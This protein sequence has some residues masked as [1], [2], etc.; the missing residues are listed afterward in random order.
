MSNND[1][2]TLDAALATLDSNY[3]INLINN[4]Q[5]IGGL[6]PPIRLVDFPKPISDKDNPSAI[7]C[8]RYLRKGGG[9]VIVAPSG[10]GKSTFITAATSYWAAGRE[11]C[12]IKPARP[13]KIGVFQTEDDAD[14]MGEFRDD[15]ARLFVE[16]NFSQEENDRALSVMYEAIPIGKFVEHLKA[17][18]IARRYDLIVLNPL[19][20]F[21]DGDITKNVDLGAF[22]RHGIDPLLKNSKYGCGMVIIHHT[23]KLKTDNRGKTDFGTTDAYAGAGGAELTNWARGVLVLQEIGQ[24]TPREFFLI[25]AKRGTRL[26]WT[27][28]EGKPTT[29]RKLSHST[30]GIFWIDAGGVAA[31]N[32]TKTDANKKNEQS[33]ENGDEWSAICD[34]ALAVDKEAGDNLLTTSEFKGRLIQKPGGAI[35]KCTTS[36]K[37]CEYW[38]RLTAD[39]TGVLEIQRKLERKKNGEIGNTKEPTAF[40]S[41]PDRIAAYRKSFDNLGI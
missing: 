4:A 34:A 41:T 21:V 19:W 5:S 6:P 8:D 31:S 15:L 1:D 13:L 18:Q 25:A 38:K 36:K 40:V 35:A 3:A 32:N 26:G 37:F 24:A 11:F 30:S 12:G 9:L 20:A 14:E 29:R 33:K 10:V 7:L 39:G 17:V 22:L 27:D 16:D 2:K 28:T 23:N